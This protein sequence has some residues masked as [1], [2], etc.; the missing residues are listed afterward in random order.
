M[1][2]KLKA[3]FHGREHRQVG[4]TSEYVTDALSR[5]EW[6]DSTR[7]FDT[8]GQPYSVGPGPALEFLLRFPTS[9]LRS[10]PLRA[11]K[12]NNVVWVPAAPLGHEIEVH[13]LCYE[14]E[15]QPEFLNTGTAVLRISNGTLTD[16]RKVWLVARTVPEGQFT[17]QDSIKSQIRAQLQAR[18]T[19]PSELLNESSRLMIGFNDNGVRGC[20]EMA[21]DWLR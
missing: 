14:P 19:M 10:F 4:L 12:R 11:S 15:T 2:G 3:S 21:G 6:H 17:N 18:G 16:G 20:T 1:G 9:Q 7:H 5:A 13:M 8:W